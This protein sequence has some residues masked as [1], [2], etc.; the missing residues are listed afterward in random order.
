MAGIRVAI[1]VPAREQ[2]LLIL[3]DALV[4]LNRIQLGRR[5]GLPGLYESGVRYVREARDP[6]TG[7]RREEWRTIEDVIEHMGGD[8]EDLAAYR[9]AQLQSRG[10]PARIWLR[11][12]KAMWHV[13]VRLPDG[14][15]EDPSRKLGMHG[16]A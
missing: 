10:V 3:L 14:R 11:R 9:V 6:R 5:P 2:D 16:D 4:R 1:R 8:C 7:L 15:L 13:L 12:H